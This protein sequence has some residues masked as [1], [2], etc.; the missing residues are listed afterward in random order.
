[1]LLTGHLIWP[2][3]LVYGAAFLGEGVRQNKE[4]IEDAIQ[5]D[6]DIPSWIRSI[7]LGDKTIE[8]I[9]DKINPELES[10]LREQITQKREA[11]DELIEKIGHQVKKALHTKAEEVTILIQ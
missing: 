8:S 1:M 4:K 9:C 2:I 10:S 6:L 7:S 3:A 5:K 11:F